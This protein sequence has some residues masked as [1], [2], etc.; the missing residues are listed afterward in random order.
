MKKILIVE[1]E[2]LIRQGIIAM[3]KRSDI[4]IDEIMECKNGLEALKVLETHKIDIMITD[5]R[6]PKVN[7]VQLVKEIQKSINAPKIVVISGYDDFSYAIEMLRN[8]AKEYLLK[9]IHR[10]DIIRIIKRLDGEIIKEEHQKEAK[11]KLNHEQLRYVLL[12]KEIGASELDLIQEQFNEVRGKSEFVVICTHS[13][14]KEQIKVETLDFFSNIYGHNLLVLDP[15]LVK[16]VINDYLEWDVVGL[17]QIYSGINNIHVAVSE[18]V[19]NRIQKFSLQSRKF[20]DDVEIEMIS[21][22]EINRWVQLIGTEHVN[23][24]KESIALIVEQTKQGGFQ[25]ELFAQLMDKIVT[26]II[27]IYGG[28]IHSEELP[29]KRLLNIYNYADIQVYEQ[30]LCEAI[31]SINQKL[32]EEYNDYRNHI[33]IEQAIKFIEENYHKDINMAIV[34]NHI[35]MNYSVFSAMFKGYTGHNFVSFL[36]EIRLKEALKL[37]N[38]TDQKIN[39]I[40]AAIGYCNEKHFMKT[41]KSIYGVTP[42]EY[43]KNMQMGK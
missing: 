35:S 1:D 22:R 15:K 37:L 34:S 19:K 21:I 14:I 29:F 38:E 4:E 6:M 16:T 23:E 25:I 12:H 27:R 24:V 9:P 39:V 42:T 28:I 33:K 8:G 5:I 13:N 40:S 10:D 30:Q 41:F 20:S 31:I 26:K 3:I 36:K 2:K 11:V 18:A 7:G 17:S 32:P 43:R